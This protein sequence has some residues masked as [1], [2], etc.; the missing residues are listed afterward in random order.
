MS[1]VLRA[2]V[3]GN[4]VD[5]AGGGGDVHVG[6]DTPVGDEELWYDTDEP[7]AP[8]G[9]LY[10]AN[11]N[12]ALGIVAMGATKKWVG[13][14]LSAGLTRATDNLVFT[15]QVG[16]RYRLVCQIRAL[17]PNPTTGYAILAATGLGI[18]TNSRFCVLTAQFDAIDIEIIFDGQGA[19][20]T[21]YVDL[22]LQSASVAFS[23]E[24]TS[25]FYIEDVGP[26]GSPALPI[27]TT[28][29]A[30]TAPTFQNGWS[31]Y[32]GYT[33]VGYRKIGDM[34]YLRGLITGGTNN[35]AM[36]T[37]PVG[38]RPPWHG[39]FAVNNNNALATVSVS[40]AGLVKNDTG[41]N[42]WIEL[43]SI[44]FSVTA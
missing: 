17:Y 9:G 36:F 22:T 14:P 13:V 29:P 11:P 1:G 3:A 44:F 37:L 42:V 18:A 12:N 33:Q 43:G 16:R 8:G 31:Q 28:P 20:G 35:A 2:R 27:P 24:Q 34:V 5:V 38:F 41:T 26:N 6:T 23:D 25:C 10:V 32:A 40:N 7:A 4:W 30:W 15:S 39:H 21:Y 19:A